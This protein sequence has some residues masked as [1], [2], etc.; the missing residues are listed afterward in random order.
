MTLVEYKKALLKYAPMESFAAGLEL[1]GQE[2]KALRN[3]LGSLDGA[4]VVVRGGEAFIIGMTIPP[5]QTANIAKNYDP[6]RAR[7]LL[8][9]KKEISLLAAAESKKGLTIIPLEVYTSGRFVKARIA[10]VRGKG[11]AD[12]REDL[13]KR[14]ALRETERI[15]KSR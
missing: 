5:Y 13:K 12:H 4:R 11:K 8:L 6:E 14:D 7:R 10:I 1:S 2:V 15:L 3:R 9:T